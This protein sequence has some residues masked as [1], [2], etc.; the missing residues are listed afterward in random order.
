MFLNPIGFR[1]LTQKLTNAFYNLNWKMM[2]DWWNDHDS[3]GRVWTIVKATNISPGGFNGTGATLTAQTPR[4]VFGNAIPTAG[5]WAVGD[6]IINLV[7]SVG[8]P[9]SW[10]CTVAGTPGTW[11]S[12]GN[13]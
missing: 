3:G 4:I 11:V 2:V 12:T 9:K 13:L 6:N 1:D 8:N 10:V 7:P 5:T